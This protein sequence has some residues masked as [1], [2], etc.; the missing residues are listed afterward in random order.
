MLENDRI[1]AMAAVESFQGW[2]SSAHV[3]AFVLCR[4]TV[5]RR[6]G[7]RVR[8][9]ITADHALLAEVDVDAAADPLSDDLVQAFHNWETSEDARMIVETY[10]RDQLF[11]T[12]FA[13]AARK[14]RSLRVVLD[15]GPR[16]R[17]GT[18]RALIRLMRGSKTVREFEFVDDAHIGKRIFI[19]P[20]Y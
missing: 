10:A 4:A 15:R 8:L 5:E 18:Y 3:G 20:C 2:L 19:R 13:T 16:Y 12:E 7:R 1:F 6:D 14:T 11:G 9:R 17:D